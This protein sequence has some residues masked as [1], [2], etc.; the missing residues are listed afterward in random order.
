MKKTVVIYATLMAIC[1][2]LYKYIEYQY[3]R[4]SFSTELALGLIAIL[5][6]II[7]I[8]AGLK[9]G[10][11]VK[12]D[13]GWSINQDNNQDLNLS[14]RELEVLQ[15][16]ASGM[17]NQEIADQLFVS[18]NT[19]KTHSSNLYSKL[20]VQRRTQAIERARQLGILEHPTNG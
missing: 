18:L 19:I 16:L 13:G 7:G 20:G 3:I 4:R 5:F 11:N 9:Y 2:G 15:L 1:V 12:S 6:T 17:S 8:W 10:K 14:K